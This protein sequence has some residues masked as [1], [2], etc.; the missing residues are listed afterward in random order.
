MICEACQQKLA[1][2]HLTEIVQKTKRE[3]HLCEECAREKGISYSPQFT[4]KGFLSGLAKK[5]AAK[6][7][8]A[9]PRAEAPEPCPSCGLT[10][11]EFR[12]SGR[13]GCPTD[14]DHFEEQLVPLLKKIHGEEVQHTG[15]VPGGVSERL[16]LERRI[17]ALQKELDAAVAREEYERAA[18]LRDRIKALRAEDA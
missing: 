6:P 17:E 5:A 1:T 13:L 16:E 18:E 4:V 8:A 9:P 11:A 15:R 10:F 3:T 2:V 7:A 14:Y 12:Q